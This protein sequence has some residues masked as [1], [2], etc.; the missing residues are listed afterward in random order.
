MRPERTTSSMKSLKEKGISCLSGRMITYKINRKKKLSMMKM[1][2]NSRIP[3]KT[4]NLL[5]H[6]QFLLTLKKVPNK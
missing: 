3:M 4:V 1:K 2:S 6:N 5:L